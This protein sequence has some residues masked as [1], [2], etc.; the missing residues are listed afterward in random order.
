MIIKKIING[1]LRLVFTCIAKT[2]MLVYGEHLHVNRY[3]KFTKKTVVG[4][5]CH[6][7]GMHISGFGEIR[8]GNNFHSGTNCKIITSFHNY[9]SGNALPYDNTYISK[10]VNIGN[11]VWIGSDVIILGGVNIEDG[12]VI[13]AGSVVAKSIP[14]YGVAGG[15]P[16]NVFKYRNVDH[17][18]K[19]ENDKKYF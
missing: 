2:E 17:Y 13:Q 15:H 19:L 3:C 12:V 8:I 7:N 10:N 5:N 6:F 16:A 14:K 18:N 9:D 11:N 4:N 1:I